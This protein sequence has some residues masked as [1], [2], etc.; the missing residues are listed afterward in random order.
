ML[1]EGMISEEGAFLVRVTGKKDG[2]DLTID[3]YVNAPGLTESFEKAKI[4]HESYMTG[5][6]AFLFT[7]MFV[8]NKIS[9]KGVFPPEVLAAKERLSF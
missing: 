6:S 2:H 7:K 3:S 9:T 8:N 1:D 4:T 5:Q